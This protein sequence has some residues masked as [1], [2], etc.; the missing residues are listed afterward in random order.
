M[1]K[2]Q[3]ELCGSNN[4]VKEDGYF[5]CQYCGTKYSLEDALMILHMYPQIGFFEHWGIATEDMEFYK[6]SNGGVTLSGGECLMQADFCCEL[7]KELK[8]N[9]IKNL[10]YKIKIGAT[11]LNILMKED[12]PISHLFI[13]NKEVNKFLIRELCC[14]LI[15]LFLNDFQS[16]F[17]NSDLTDLNNCVSYCHLNF[18]FALM[19]IVKN[20]KINIFED[21]SESDKKEDFCYN[22]YLKC[23]TIIELNYEKIE[24]GFGLRVKNDKSEQLKDGQDATTGQWRAGPGNGICFL[25]LKGYL[26]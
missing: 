10:D 22:S 12:N 2:I 15:V 14:Y 9:G 26:S 20:T 19:L 23:K 1:K 3:C 18:L 6:T 24:R 7:L 21:L 13:Y 4:L 11:Y 17:K 5:V 25:L 16:G 8:S